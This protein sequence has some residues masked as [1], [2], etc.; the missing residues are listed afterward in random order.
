MIRNLI[1]MGNFQ[2]QIEEHERFM[3]KVYNKIFEVDTPLL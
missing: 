1:N 3:D 2:E